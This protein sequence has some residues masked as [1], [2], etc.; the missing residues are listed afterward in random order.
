MKISVWNCSDKCYLEINDRHVF[1]Y[2]ADQSNEPQDG[3]I[4]QIQFNQDEPY[5]VDLTFYRYEFGKDKEIIR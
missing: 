2:V 1:Q 5:I 3:D 4:E